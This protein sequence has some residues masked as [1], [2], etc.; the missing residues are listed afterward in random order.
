[1]VVDPMEWVVKLLSEFINHNRRKNARET[2]PIEA[3]DWAERKCCFQ[4]SESFV[5]DISIKFLCICFSIICWKLHHK[6]VI[7]LA[8]SH[9]GI[10]YTQL[11]SILTDIIFIFVI[12]LSANKKF[13]RLVAGTVEHLQLN[14]M[15]PKNPILLYHS[16]SSLQHILNLSFHSNEGVK[17][18]NMY[19]VFSNIYCMLE[20]LFLV[21]WTIR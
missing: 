2:N 13:S 9:A 7:L 19:Y 1:M 5:Q 3:S 15:K 12:S 17:H 14:L 11:C 21:S 18:C 16:C 20:F 4:D 8:S 6:I 10:L